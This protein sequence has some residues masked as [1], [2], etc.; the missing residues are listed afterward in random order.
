MFV[1]REHCFI[2]PSSNEQPGL[3]GEGLEREDLKFNLRTTH[4]IFTPQPAVSPLNKGFSKTGISYEFSYISLGEKQEAAKC[5]VRAR[6]VPYCEL[7]SLK[8]RER[9]AHGRNARPMPT[10][11]PFN[12]SPQPAKKC[13]HA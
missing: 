7:T 12:N 9:A 1:P 10:T 3:E 4:L 11:V 13:E 5:G 6:S 8:R 2:G